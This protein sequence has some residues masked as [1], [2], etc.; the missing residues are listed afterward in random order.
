MYDVNPLGPMMHLKELDRQAAPKLR[1]LRSRRSNS[2]S[3]TGL[4]A[5]VI[6]VLQRVHAFRLFDTGRGTPPSGQE[7]HRAS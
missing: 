3:L 5:S 7:L 2:F 1:L 6:A 4:S